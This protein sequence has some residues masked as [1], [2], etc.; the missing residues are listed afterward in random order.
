MCIMLSL[1]VKCYKGDYMQFSYSLWKMSKFN[2]SVMVKL[3]LMGIV[4]CVDVHF[5]YI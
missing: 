3:Y 4:R 5:A 1:V 2:V